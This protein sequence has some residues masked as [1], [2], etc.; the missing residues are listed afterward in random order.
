[1]YFVEFVEF[2]SSAGIELRCNILIKPGKSPIP[3]IIQATLGINVSVN[4]VV[5]DRFEFAILLRDLVAP[6]M[7]TSRNC[8]TGM[9]F[10]VNS[11]FFQLGD[12]VFTLVLTF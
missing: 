9:S 7:V 10:P 11:Q 3:T 1:L 12:I 2:V 4:S 8:I 5:K 6:S